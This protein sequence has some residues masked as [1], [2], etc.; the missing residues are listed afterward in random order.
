MIICRGSV[1]QQD[2][3][4]ADKQNNKGLYQVGKKMNQGAERHLV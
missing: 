2:K 4:S 1:S 3:S